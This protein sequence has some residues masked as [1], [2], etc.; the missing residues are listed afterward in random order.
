MTFTINTFMIIAM[1]FIVYALVGFSLFI[2]P[3]IKEKRKNKKS[4]KS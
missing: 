3:K 2:E 1:L 4:Q